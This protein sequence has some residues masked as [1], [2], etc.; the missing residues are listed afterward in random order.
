MKDLLEGLA[1][2]N[3][4]RI[5]KFQI[6][7]LEAIEPLLKLPT[8]GSVMYPQEDGSVIGFSWLF[9]IDGHNGWESAGGDGTSDGFWHFGPINLMLVYTRDINSAWQRP[10]RTPIVPRSGIAGSWDS[11]MVHTANVPIEVP[12][13][14]T[15]GASTDQVWLYVG[16]SNHSHNK[17]PL[18]GEREHRF[19]VAKWRMDGFA[20][21]ED[22]NNSEDII[23]TKAINF[24]GN[25]LT[26]NADVKSD[27]YI[28]VKI[29]PASGGADLKG[30]S[31]SVTGDNQKHIVKW[32][33][34]D[35]IASCAEQDVVFEIRIKNA[36]LYSLDFT[37]DAT[38]S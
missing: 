37:P 35:N 31:D 22:T 30:L 25:Q 29:K 7:T 10:T 9:S 32:S 11:D 24:S 21:L 27:G 3:A 20:A 12:Q 15:S 2:G 4:P 5:L 38:G 36:A 13:A 17:D 26:L 18:T 19:G 23:T 8:A 33:G 6:H 1:R 16:G 34:D 14:E 28:H